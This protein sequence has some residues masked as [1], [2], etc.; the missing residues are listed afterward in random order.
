MAGPTKPPKEGS[1]EQLERDN[2]TYV[3]ADKPVSEQGGTVGEADADIPGLD[4]A[5]E[6]AMRDADPE[7][8]KQGLR[9]DATISSSRVF[10][11]GS[12]IAALG[13]DNAT[14]QTH[15]EPTNQASDYSPYGHDEDLQTRIGNEHMAGSAEGKIAGTIGAERSHEYYLEEKR[16]EEDRMAAY[17]AAQANQEAADAWKYATMS[18]EELERQ[19]NRVAE[20]ADNFVQ[21]ATAVNTRIST[22]IDQ[23]RQLAER[24]QQVVIEAQRQRQLLNRQLENETDPRTREILEARM[25]ALD[26]AIAGVN[27]NIRIINGYTDEQGVYREGR[28]ETFMRYLEANETAIQYAT[29]GKQETQQELEALRNMTGDQAKA[30]YI[31][32]LEDRITQARDNIANGRGSREDNERMITEAQRRLGQLEN[33]SGDEAK[34][35]LQRRLEQRLTRFDERLGELQNRSEALDNARD[36]LARYRDASDAFANHMLEL[37]QTENPTQQQLDRVRE[38]QEELR[39]ADEQSRADLAYLNDQTRRLAQSHTADAADVNMSVQQAQASATASD[40]DRD[41]ARLGDDLVQIQARTH[42]LQN[43]N[44]SASRHRVRVEAGLDTP[45]GPRYRP[46]ATQEETQ[47]SI[48]RAVS[49]LASAKQEGRDLTREEFRELSNLPGLSWKVVRETAEDIGVRAPTR[50]DMGYTGPRTTD[51]AEASGPGQYGGGSYR[52]GGF[53][54]LEFRLF[55]YAPYS[56][57]TVPYSPIQPI[58]YSETP[59]VRNDHGISGGAY[60]S[61]ADNEFNDTNPTIAETGGVTP[62]YSK[63]WYETAWNATSSFMSSVWSGIDTK[64][65][66]PTTNPLGQQP[67]VM[68]ASADPNAN[69]ITPVAGTGGG[70]G[71]MA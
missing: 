39:K 61:F 52:S 27:Q 47:T 40:V 5:I 28:K 30:R 3:Y 26:A 70:G 31:S 35:A 6:A 45:E 44:E 68:L 1:R 13:R 57:T 41:A 8:Y 43:I 54:D 48:D 4:D 23:D 9:E 63:P 49:V 62:S 53:N 65:A 15:S 22:F 17:V 14:P 34:A 18:F 46:A 64:P 10:A 33:M 37:S 66:N 20:R 36:S 25:G 11:A 67:G 7:A 29:L 12:L 42:I 60:S 19:S 50:E 51:G 38:L 69:R 2:Q 21:S 55:G 32:H 16:R 56:A 71:A 59:L 24:E 58:G